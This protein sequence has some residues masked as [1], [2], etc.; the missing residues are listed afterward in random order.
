MKNLPDSRSSQP[1]SGKLED[2]GWINLRSNSRYRKK[3]GIVTITGNSDGEIAIPK[4]DG[5]ITLGTLPENC[6]PDTNILAVATSK[7]STGY[8]LQVRVFE[9]GQVSITN[10]NPNSTASYWGFSLS[11]PV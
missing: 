9:T 11:Y 8:L 2:T 3:A 1:L 4:F 7:A 5:T 10:L 6:R